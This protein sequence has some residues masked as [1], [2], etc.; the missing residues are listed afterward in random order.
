MN[1]TSILLLFLVVISFYFAFRITK[2]IASKSDKGKIWESGFLF[3]FTFLIVGSLNLFSIFFSYTFIW[4][5]GF[6]A[7]VEQKHE[8]V[9]VDYV[10]EK[11]Y[12]KSTTGSGSYPILLYFPVVKFKN[13]KGIETKKKLDL[14]SN[15]PYKIGQTIKISANDA[16]KNANSIEFEPLFSVI[17]ISLTSVAM[18]FFV[19][20]ASFGFNKTMKE[21]VKIARNIS[22]LLFL[23]NGIISLWMYFV[24]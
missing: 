17:A 8:A 9:V 13:E 6:R 20:V 18:F 1:S 24:V 14:T 23:I 19:L 16:S 11:S 22:V 2:K 21:R 12:R 15:H 3:L 7:V 10:I 5:K 4:E